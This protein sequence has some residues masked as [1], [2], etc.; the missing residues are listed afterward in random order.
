MFTPGVSERGRVC[1]G[2]GVL[3]QTWLK[4]QLVTDTIAN[5]VKHNLSSTHLSFPTRYIL[6]YLRC[7][8]AAWLVSL[9][10]SPEL[11][12]GVGLTNA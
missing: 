5:K 6:V 4:K 11:P 9:V 1:S 10:L 2:L 7:L 12:R 8:Q 3:L